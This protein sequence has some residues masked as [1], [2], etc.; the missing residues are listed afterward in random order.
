MNP[1]PDLA[2]QHYQGDAGRRYHTEKRGVPSVAVPWLARARAELFRDRIG[3][4][5][6][7]L[8]Y[9]VGAG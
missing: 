6:A 5:D 7:V 1:A 9:G 2:W 3:S 4:G 8:E